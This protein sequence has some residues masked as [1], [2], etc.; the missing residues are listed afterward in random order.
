MNSAYVELDGQYTRSAR[1]DCWKPPVSTQPEGERAG[2]AVILLLYSQTHRQW[3]L[4]VDS[5]HNLLPVGAGVVKWSGGDAC[6][7]HRPARHP[8]DYIINHRT[9]NIY[10][11]RSNAIAKLHRGI[12][13]VDK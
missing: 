3:Q 10:T 1:H 6:V 12:D 4:A 13:L 7:A 9:G 8:T 11:S 2:D 5:S